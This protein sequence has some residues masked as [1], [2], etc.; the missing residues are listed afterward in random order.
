MSTG[1]VDVDLLDLGGILL[2]AQVEAEVGLLV[3]FHST[4]DVGVW[5]PR[6]PVQSSVEGVERLHPKLIPF[7][8]GHDEVVYVTC[9]GTLNN[10]MAVLAKP[11]AGF[12][13]Q[14]L[15]ASLMGGNLVH[16]AVPLTWCA[17]Q[18]IGCSKKSYS[19]ALLHVQA[20]SKL[21]NWNCKHI[22]GAL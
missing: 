20:L 10:A 6:A 17:D 18:S 15:H 21:L 14:T 12:T 19:L 13:N 1:L 11:N 9:N 3:H 2:M 4:V 22:T 5:L 7:I 16:V 8:A